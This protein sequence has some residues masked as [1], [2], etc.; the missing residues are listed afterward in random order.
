MNSAETMGLICLRYPVLEGKTPPPGWPLGDEDW[1]PF[2]KLVIDFYVRT[3]SA[4]N[5]DD[6][7]L[8]WMG[9]PVR[10][11]FIQGPGFRG[12]PTNHQRLWPAVRAGRRPARITS[13]PEDCRRFGR[14]GIQQRQDQR[15]VRIRVGNAAPA[16][17]GRRGRI[18]AQAQRGLRYSAELSTAEVCPYTAR[19]LDTTLR[20][21]SPYLPGQGEPERCVSFSPP[22]VPKAYWRDA[23]GGIADRAEVA[24]WLETDPDVQ[25]ARGLGIWSNLN[26]RI[27][28]NTPYF[29]TAEHSAQL[30]G[31]R[32]RTLEKRFKEGD[33]NVLS[34]STTMEMGVDIGGLSAVIMKQCAPQF[35]ETT[36]SARGPCR[37]AWRRGVLRG[38]ALSEFAAW[39]AGVR[40]PPLAL[41]FDH[42]RPAGWARQRAPRPTSCQCPLPR[43][44]PRGTGCPA[45]QNW[46]V[47][48]G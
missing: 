3:A 6:N 32:L 19:V 44:F 2:L 22:R 7:Y 45:T 34:C 25:E 47:L 23:A 10:K 36:S 14:L 29:E 17:P 28:A 18:P 31:T 30:N 42:R 9:I 27:A 37:A 43:N 24:Y 38:H 33:L 41:H 1:T 20:G 12:S 13:A 46:A 11:G 39:R 5:V 15:S 16:L 4:V 26:D 21:L 40:Q 35:G 8:W 48:R